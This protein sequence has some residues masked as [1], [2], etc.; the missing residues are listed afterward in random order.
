MMKQSL[1]QANT[2][3]RFMVTVFAFVCFLFPFNFLSASDLE[4]S[5]LKQLNVKSFE[6]IDFDL[7]LWETRF[8]VAIRNVSDKA[9]IGKHR[10]VVKTSRNMLNADGYTADGYPFLDVCSN[11]DCTL[12]SA[13]KI[14]KDIVFRSR[15]TDLFFFLKPDLEAQRI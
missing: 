15:F 1:V 11:S 9:S 10:V 3:P 8:R 6:K 12:H 4:T 2:H 7:W 14:G 13:E 5:S